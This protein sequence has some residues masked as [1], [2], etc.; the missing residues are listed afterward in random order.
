MKF[1]NI[2]NKSYQTKDGVIWASRSVA[3]NG[4][5]F[6]KFSTVDELYVL[7]IKRSK[8][9]I[10]EAGKWCLPCGYIDFGE[11]ISEATER[12]IFEETGFDINQYIEYLDIDI[13][14]FN[15]NDNP[16]ANRQNI[17]FSSIKFYNNI[18]KFPK[19]LD[20]TEESDAN[21]WVLIRDLD[22]YNIAFNH[23]N[24]IKLALKNL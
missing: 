8:T 10:D 13:P 1:N 20:K 16:K 23:E 19:L 11:T 15:I 3:V 12:E 5:I 6:I 14:N 17:S 22:L 24:I 4:L 21:N 2:P 7:L 18:P 9:M